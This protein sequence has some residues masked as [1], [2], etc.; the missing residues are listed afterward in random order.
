LPP[1]LLPGVQLLGQPIVLCNLGIALVLLLLP[2]PLEGELLIQ[3]HSALLLLN[4]PLRGCGSRYCCCLL[5]NRRLQCVAVKLQVLVQSSLVLSHARRV[6][7]SHS[8]QGVQ[9]IAALLNV[10]L[11]RVQPVRLVKATP[12]LKGVQRCVVVIVKA[13]VCE[14]PGPLCNWTQAQEG[15]RC[16]KKMKKVDSIPN[17]LRGS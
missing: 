13:A 7:V 8:E 3:L 10:E 15:K 14:H 2:L 11:C 1:L 12:H 4:L 9:R 16:P 17:V 5:L 6:R